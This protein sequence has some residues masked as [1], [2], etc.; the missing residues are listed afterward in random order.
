MLGVS[1]DFTK[2]PPL[3]PLTADHAFY[4]NRKLGETNNFFRNQ[5]SISA[6]EV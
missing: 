1:N 3:L 2:P 6:V 5:Q 4:K